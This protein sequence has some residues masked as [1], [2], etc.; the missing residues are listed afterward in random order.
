MGKIERYIFRDTFFIF[1]AAL[2]ILTATIW[3]TQALREVDLLTSKG[4]TLLVFLKLTILTIPSLVM[5]LAPV[6][7]FIAIVTCF[8]RLNGDSELVV[9]STSGM[10]PARLL[11]PVVAL[12]FIV[13]LLIA[14]MS[15]W[16]MPNSYR[17]I[18]TLVTKIRTDV[19]TRIV[20]AGHFVSLEKG[21]VFH[22]RE[23]AAGGA[24]K[25]I[26]IQDRRDPGKVNTYI[27]ETGRTIE[28]ENKNFL[29]LEKGSIQ[30]ST[31]K[32]RDPAIVQFES[33]AIDLA[34]FSPR[35]AVRYKPREYLTSELRNLDQSK[36]Y[37]RDNSGRFRAEL[38]NRFADP[39]YALVFA[40]IAFAALGQPKTTRQGRGVAIAVSI[41]C[42]A[43]V[44]VT[45]FGL[46]AF[47]AQTQW[48]IPLI[49]IVPLASIVVPLIVILKPEWLSVLRLPGLTGKRRQELQT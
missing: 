35:G 23:R 6:A 42:V 18:G 26:F 16:V 36:P 47:A 38:H 29:I 31:R 11:R 32:E 44:R 17:T 8:N 12:A 41:A 34:Q 49:Y 22:Y 7:L 48:A 46:S 24:L 27:A 9:M 5:I 14:T 2:V 10:S 37:I 19:L 13:L 40:L 15:L 20:Q 30:R 25:G 45:G 1:A 33:Y 4:Q 39:L 21:F 43:A 28:N 3:V